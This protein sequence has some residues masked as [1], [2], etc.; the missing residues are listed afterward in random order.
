[1]ETWKIVVACLAGGLFAVPNLINTLYQDK[2]KQREKRMDKIFDKWWSSEGI[3]LIAR[4]PMPEQHTD[5]AKAVFEAAFK[6]GAEQVPQ[7]APS[8]E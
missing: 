6:M 3:N 1:L 4:Y 5:F 7:Q 8:E 2:L